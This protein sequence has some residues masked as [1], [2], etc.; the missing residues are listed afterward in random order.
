MARH[1]SSLKSLTGRQ[2]EL[3]GGSALPKQGVKKIVLP[4][5]HVIFQNAFEQ[6]RNAAREDRV[7][8][9]LVPSR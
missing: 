8:S 9:S 4:L 6:G 7:R 1:N 5:V 2:P 3:L